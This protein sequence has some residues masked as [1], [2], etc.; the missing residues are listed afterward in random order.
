[1]NRLR[2]ST[3]PRK[4]QRA[5]VGALIA[6]ALVL[7]S[8]GASGT[9]TTTSASTLKAS[10]AT[11]S[12]IGHTAVSIQGTKFYINGT[13]TSPGKPAEG[14]LLNTRMAQAIF[15]DENPSTKGL[16]AY[17]DTK[18][19]DPQRNTDEFVSQ[20]PTY[21]AHGIRMVTVGLQGGCP[22]SY[23]TDPCGSGAH[24]W[25]VTAFN[26]D[27][28][29]KAAWMSRLQEVLTAADQNGI[30]VIVQFFYHGQNQRLNNPDTT[31]AQK[32]AVNNITD[33]LVKGGYTNVLVETANE[34]NAGYEPYTDCA[35]EAAVVKQVQDRS[36][37]DGRRLATAV[38]YTGDGMPSDDV[39]A[40][41]DY[42][43]LHGNGI[44]ATQLLDLINRVK[45]DTAYKGHSTPIV[46]NEDSTS[47]DNLNAAVGAGASWGNLDTGTN[48]YHDGFQR[49]PVNWA[50]N[51]DAKRA[52]FNRTL[53][54]AGATPRP[55]AL[56]YGG[57]SSADYH[58]GLTVTATLTDAAGD[59]VP[60]QPVTFTLSANDVDL[61]TCSGTTGPSGDTA[62]LL[63]PSDAAGAASLL[64]NYAGSDSFEPASQTVAV[65]IGREQ[66]ALEYRGD[67]TFI[68][69]LPGTLSAVLT[70]DGTTPLGGRS[71]TFT[72]GSGDSAQS[73]TATTDATGLAS[74][75]PGVTAQALG[76]AAVAAA[77]S[78]DH[79]YLPS[80]A[81]GEVQ[82][83]A[84]KSGLSYTGATSGDYHDA[85]TLKAVLA[86]GESPVPGKSIL[87]TL[88]S[89]NCVGQTDDHGAAACSITPSEGAGTYPLTAGFA[90]DQNFQ[91]SSVSSSFIV[92]KE[93]SKLVYSGVT[94]IQNDGAANFAASLTEDGD[95]TVPLANRPITFTLGTGPAA[96]ACTATTGSSGTASCSISAVSQLI[97]ATTV[98]ASFAGDAN[99][100][101]ASAQP[102][103]DILAASTTPAP[104]NNGTTTLA[105]TGGGVAARALPMT[106]KETFAL[107]ML[108]AVSGVFVLVRRRRAGRVPTL[109]WRNRQ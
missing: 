31:T 56:A 70:E 17:P 46:V 74:C 97:G 92:G 23:S 91:P 81:T 54:L 47:V 20:L 100:Q 95:T 28:S 63:T 35:N 33:W 53:E 8:C 85:A 34:C 42:V 77:F 68:N 89:K 108:L 4:R 64:I 43:L 45:S 101:P 52:F 87:F 13:V 58:D 106:G 9:A 90:G 36:A 60:G 1:M 109:I 98:T 61:G 88:G 67:A 18:K 44:N 71:I 39:L 62:C 25:V 32:A 14:L 37:T 80:S 57:P 76:S 2:R 73:C 49:P 24:D 84:I 65:A 3:H 16:W 29:L 107:G 7:A 38:S 72:L 26:D 83:A 10:A 103:V 11:V 82:V 102:A 105:T 94:A 48:N 104:S 5:G 15:D 75:A 66:S 69:G 22:S 40:Q 21:A 12:G 19:W 96:Q 27:G 86:S 41:E 78:G 79:L 50:I 30:V 6:T 93:E 55:T 59:S 99:Y 51:T